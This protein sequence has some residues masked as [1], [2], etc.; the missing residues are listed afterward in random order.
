M[1][2]QRSAHLAAI[3]AASSDAIVSIGTDHIV[4]T[5]NAGAQRLFGYSEGEAI[6]RSIVELII[7]NAYAAEHF[8][9]CAA[10]MNSRT[11]ILR[12][13][14]LRDKDGR[15]LPV[16]IN[17]SP[18]VDGTAKVTGLSIILR[19]IGERQRAEKEL[20]R[21][22]ERQALLLKVTSDLISA[23]EVNE[24]S[25]VT[26]RH[27]GPAFEADICLNFR[28]DPGG[29]RLRLEFWSGLS[30]ELL[31]AA[32]S[33]EIGQANW[34]M[35]AESR[36]PIVADKQRIACHPN[37]A[38][39]RALGTT[40]FACYPLFASD[41]RLLGAFAIASRTRES[42]TDDEVAWLGTVMNFLAQA[43]ER[44]EAE[45]GLRASEE[46]L[47]LAQNAA[48][49]GYSDFD[50]ASGNLVWSKQTRRLIG[51]GPDEPASLALL[52]SHVHPEDRRNVEQQIARRHSPN[53][54]HLYHVEFR[55]LTQNGAFRWLE[56]QGRV[57]TD[58]ARRPIRALGV[59]R[60]ITKR[61]SA[62]EAR[63]RLAAIVTSSADAIISE[64][65]GGIVTSWNVGAERMFG[66]ASSDMVGRSIHQVIPTDRE[67]EE[68]MVLGR[69][70]KGECIKPY[71][72]LRLT[73]DG[74]KIDVSIMVSPLHDAEGKIT[75]VSKIV[76]DITDRKRA[77]E[78]LQASKDRLQ[79]ALDA[80]R[81][82]SFQYDRVRRVFSWDR[83]V[84]EI[85][86]IVEDEVHVDDFMK[87]MHQ[88]DV[89]LVRT[90]I[91]TPLSAPANPAVLEHRFWRGGEIRW[92]EVHRLAYFEGAGRG[93][94]AVHDVGTV[95]DITERKER[96][97]KE[98][99][100]MREINHRAKNMLSVVDAIAHQTAA[101]NPKD[102][103]ER[104][105]E[106]IQSLSANQDLLVR[107][108][109]KGVEID[110]L[111][112]AQLAHFADLIGRR[113]VVQGP[114]LR[115]NPAAV[116]AIGLALHELTTN[117]GKY[118]AL[119]TEEGRVDIRW[120]SDG[121]TLTISWTEHD[122]PVSPPKQR[123]FGT[124]VMEA[125]AERSVDGKVDLNYGPSGM[126]WRLTCPAANA[127]ERG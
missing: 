88:D 38:W 31:E 121:S 59:F 21:H 61:K 108:E 104:F 74:R 33:L 70:A 35:A 29:R 22:A 98:Q 3:V 85:F 119:S 60:D 112:H 40:A 16:E 6:G 41:G 117:A 51:V 43:W 7:P 94:R 91:K 93:R 102:F 96:E 120:E 8:A 1:E 106:R 48:G 56:E 27:I 32:R 18:I 111:V 63:A 77:E 83:R 72:T 28:L 45:H 75:V 125:M 103:I 57:E 15:F 20:R 24:L 109:W 116:Q 79:L 49:L 78:A 64:T 101:K 73:K 12:E 54:D 55:I 76:R 118:G 89:E 14:V 26:F 105:S 87:L 81:L 92:V 42:F 82:G 52:L 113:I 30:P 115:L 107:N 23:A 17:I 99:L 66:Y 13:T 80:A 46:R 39:I 58:T 97:E 2:E 90:F 95:Q 126:T 65:V 44:L 36:Q 11:A 114:K 62:E 127:L 53:S 84:K 100:L 69:V 123:G 122:G 68:K 67:A 71:E 110:D 47:R 34:G 9:I 50:F 10:A 124:I 5:W 37:D 4:Q 25:G 86:G 19:D